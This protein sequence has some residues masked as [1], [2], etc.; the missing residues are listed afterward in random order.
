MNRHMKHIDPKPFLEAIKT[1]KAARVAADTLISSE[2]NTVTDRHLAR[3]KKNTPVG[4]S[5][6]S[7]TL[8]DRWDRSV[9]HGESDGMH[10]E[11]FNTADHAAYWEFGHRQT[12]GRVVFIELAPGQSLYGRPAI[13]VKKGKHTGKW[14]IY[15]RLVKSYVKGSFVMTDSEKRAQRELDAAAKRIGQRIKEGLG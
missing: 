14:G 7:P 11:V 8:R 13:E 12:P 4:I 15:I 5:P 2:L 3:C 9:I 1:V 10:S 6:D